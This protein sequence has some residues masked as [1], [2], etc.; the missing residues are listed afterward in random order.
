MKTLL[1]LFVLF[2]SS[3]V[4]A[5]WKENTW[6]AEYSEGLGS[7]VSVNGLITHGDRFYIR[8]VKS[9]TD[10]CEL[11]EL[12]FSF[13]T[14]MNNSNILNLNNQILSVKFNDENLYAKILHPRKFLLGHRVFIWFAYT[15][16][17]DVIELYKDIEIFKLEL[18]DSSEFQSSVY[19]DILNNEWSTNN[20]KNSIHDAKKL[21]K[22]N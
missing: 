9:E 4:V 3:S 20:F 6:V 8:I 14:T 2:F 19:F 10:A 17:D 21:C 1:T 15:P 7:T 11:G 18:L 12:F 5:E 22:S 16:L 13:Y